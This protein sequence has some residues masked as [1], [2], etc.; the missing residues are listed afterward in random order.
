MSS[1]YTPDQQAEM[2]TMLDAAIGEEMA[3]RNSY[4]CNW[5]SFTLP[6]ADWLLL[7]GC[8]VSTVESIYN[9]AMDRATSDEGDFEQMIDLLTGHNTAVNAAQDAQTDLMTALREQSVPPIVE[10]PVQDRDVTVRTH[11][12]VIFNVALGLAR[13]RV[14]IEVA[15]GDDVPDT[16]AKVLQVWTRLKPQ[17][18]AAVPGFGAG[19][20]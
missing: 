3:S 7:F 2:I 16:A 6:E 11:V 20:D 15:G 9:L 14:E 8:A 10:G 13:A 1:T 19:L 5:H 17:M 18:A 12:H 4:N